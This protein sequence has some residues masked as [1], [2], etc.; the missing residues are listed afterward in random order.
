MTV[1][2]TLLDSIKFRVLLILIGVALIGLLF[3]ILECDSVS[4]DPSAK[5]INA[6]QAFLQGDPSG[7]APEAL[8]K[9]IPTRDQTR[10]QM[11]PVNGNDQVT[12][13]PD[14]TSNT[15][16]WPLVTPVF[17][18]IC[19]EKFSRLKLDQQLAV[20]GLQQ[21]YTAFYNE[22]LLKDAIDEEIWNDKVKEFHQD[23]VMKLGSEVADDLCRQ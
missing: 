7:T 3:L 21:E 12:P 11:M 6:H 4:G 16:P 5:L 8:A 19:Q 10:D 15:E 23:L 20:A 14:E 17:N 2:F 1:F 22:T 13:E 9:T 18:Q